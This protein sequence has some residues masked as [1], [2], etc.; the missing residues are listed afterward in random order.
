M[1]GGGERCHDAGGLAQPVAVIQAAAELLS[2]PPGLLGGTRCGAVDEQAQRTQPFGRIRLVVENA[3]GLRGHDDGAR[4]GV[5]LD[6]VDPTGRIEVRHH[7]VRVCSGEHGEG[8]CGGRCVIQRCRREIDLVGAEFLRSG[9]D[10]GV[11]RDRRLAEAHTLGMAR[12]AAGV[13]D[14]DD[15]RRI[16]EGREPADRRRQSR[17]VPPAACDHHVE[18]GCSQ[19]FDAR[20]IGERQGGSNVGDQATHLR[21]GQFG[22]Q[23][24]R[25]GADTGC[26]QVDLEVHRTVGGAD[27]NPVTSRHPPRDEPRRQ[28][29]DPIGQFGVR[30]RR[31]VDDD[32]FPTRRRSGRCSE[33][34]RDEAGGVTARQRPDH[35]GGSQRI[36]IGGRILLNNPPIAP[37]LRPR[38]GFRAPPERRERWLAALPSSRRLP[39]GSPAPERRAGQLAALLG[40]LRGPAWPRSGSQS[41]DLPGEFG[42]V[43]RAASRR[44]EVGDLADADVGEHAQHEGGVGP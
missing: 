15:I 34:I 30:D 40:G 31:A 35:A 23:R 17:G 37:G 9:V 13:D 25:G 42:A 20:R 39:T 22:C 6:R 14:Q 27:R 2:H 5:G 11:G 29:V 36:R 44:Q 3:L 8:P 4:H 16:G 21:V 7:D 28:A 24:H 10:G 43:H 19:R 18:P 1:I 33:Q 38:S 12:G 41:P 32:R 26:C